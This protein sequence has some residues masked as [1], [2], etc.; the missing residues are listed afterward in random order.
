MSI[1]CAVLDFS[2]KPALVYLL[3]DIE[4]LLIFPYAL[5]GYRNNIYGLSI[6]IL[7]LIVITLGFVFELGR[8]ALHIDSRQSIKLPDT[9]KNHVVE[10][11]AKTTGNLNSNKVNISTANR[12]YSTLSNNQVSN[13]LFITR[14]SYA[15]Y[16][17]SP[18]LFFFRSKKA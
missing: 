4:I 11:I 7:V 8:G 1:A 14:F 3:L 5:S 9:S 13:S 12:T 6:T 10:L 15:K 2:R 17:R 16:S 18:L